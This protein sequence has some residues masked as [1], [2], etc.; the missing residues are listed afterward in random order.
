MSGYDFLRSHQCD[1]FKRCLDGFLADYSTAI[2]DISNCSKSTDLCNLLTNCTEDPL[3]VEV[4]Q[5][6]LFLRKHAPSLYNFRE[7]GKSCSCREWAALILSVKLCS[8][9]PQNWKS[10]DVLKVFLTARPSKYSSNVIKLYD[11]VTKEWDWNS[12]SESDFCARWSDSDETDESE[13][14]SYISSEDMSSEDT[15][16]Q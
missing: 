1:Y 6:A 8:N 2:E 15:H 10:S 9:D 7:N 5:D 11:D 13:N 14:E 16:E 3:V 12:E 4:Y